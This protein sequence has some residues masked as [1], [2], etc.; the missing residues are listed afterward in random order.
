MAEHSGRYRRLAERLV[1]AGIEVWAADQ[2]GHGRTA[3]LAVNDAGRGGLLGHCHD[4]DGFA[5]ANADIRRINLAMKAA[6]PGIPLFL[7]GHSWGSFLVRQYVA[8]PES[9]FPEGKTL[10]GCVLSGTRGPGGFKVR[11]G[12]PITALIVRLW[13]ERHGSKPARALADGPYRKAF[14]PARTPFDWLSTDGAEV[15]AY[16]ADPL[17]GQLCSAGFYRD[18]ARGLLALDSETA[19]RRIP[20]DLPILLIYGKHDPVGDYGSGPAALEAEYR[21]LGI[22]EVEGAPMAESRHEPFNDVDRE[23]AGSRLLSWITR[24]ISHTSG[25][26]A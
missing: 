14:R 13:G 4:G 19:L 17:C 8:S 16:M 6:D 18:L 12:V 11:A 1:A 15:D 23:E 22:G 26:E 21:R 5:A 2:R 3:D 10:S 20:K 7:L 9:E 25:R 24:H